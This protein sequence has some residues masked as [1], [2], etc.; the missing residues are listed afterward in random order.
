MLFENKSTCG[1]PVKN[2][3]GMDFREID[4]TLKLSKGKSHIE[5][6]II[7]MNQIRHFAKT[8]SYIVYTPEKQRKEL[9]LAA[10]LYL[11]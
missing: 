6:Q 11:A 4:K 3:I 5:L 2:N 7:G 10:L 9:T 1:S 8:I